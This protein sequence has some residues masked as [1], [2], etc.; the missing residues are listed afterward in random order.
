VATPNDFGAK[1][2]PPSHPE[3]LDWL[4]SELVRNGWHL[5]PIHK[6]ILM[7]NAYRQSSAYSAAS[8]QRDPDNVY[9]WRF[10]PRRLEAEAI[11]DCI[12]ACSGRLDLTM[13][14]PGSLDES[15]RRRSIYFTVKR[16]QMIPSM[17]LFDR[18]ESLVS[19]STRPSTTTAPQALFFMNSPIV[20]S[21]AEAF[22]ERLARPA[23]NSTDDAIRLAFH[24]S[25][26][27]DPTDKELELWRTMIHSDI[28]HYREEGA[29]DA[30]Q[31]AM[32][33]CCQLL[34]STSEF[35]YVR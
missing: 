31:L 13:F 2:D 7:S 25:V 24:I 6:L 10:Q 1:G 29:P 21:A 9:C 12:L 17:Q 16:S 33:H 34:L 26:F 4:A 23:K 8:A 11:R 22:A 15:T 18:P 30:H 27:R 28:D 20:R 5:K 14:G 35:L 32:V 19:I 3:L